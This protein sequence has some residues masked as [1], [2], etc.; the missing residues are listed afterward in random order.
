MA[1]APLA[2]G[3]LT[4]KFQL[5]DQFDAKDMRP[6]NKLFQRENYAHAL[7]AIEQLRPIVAGYQTSL[8]SLA[9]AWLLATPN[10]CS[11]WSE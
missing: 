7:Q 10:E 1:Y 2:Q 9:L 11:R 8:S 6:R 4:G 5:V 3:L